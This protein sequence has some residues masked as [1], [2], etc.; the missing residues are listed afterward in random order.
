MLSSSPAGRIK[1]LLGH[2]NVSGAELSRALA[3]PSDVTV[4]DV[5]AGDYPLS[6]TDLVA[7]ADLLDVP[8]TVLTG[9]V[10]M[11][12]HLGVSL[13]LGAV[14][15]ADVPSEALQ[16]ADKVLGYRVLLDSWLGA[17]RSP[18]AGVGMSADSYFMRAGQ[19]SAERVRDALQLDEDPIPDLVAL[20]EALGYPVTFRRLPEGMHGL[21]IRDEREGPPTRLIIVS[22]QDPWTRQRFTLAHELCHALYD[23]AGQVIVDL[24]EVPDRLPELRAESFARHLLLPSAALTEDVRSAREEGTSLEL[25]TA[26]LM[27]R[28]GMSKQA[29]LR[30]LGDDGLAESGETSAVQAYPVHQLMA[31]SGLSEQ[32]QTLSA[33]QGEPSGS[34]WLVNRALEAYGNG[35]VGAHVVADLLGQDL[36]TTER[37]LIVQG[38]ATPLS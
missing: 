17:V 8:V 3:L 38:W 18:L 26:C 9:Q 13:R 7:I 24:V 1:L 16:Y 12:G 14:E 20:T 21:N 35:W 27:V 11:D 5:L 29:V 25:L 34:P 36:E 37:Q 31:R 33:G 4:D 15:A 6:A 23:D 10:P 19:R 32:W 2:S 28:W 30:A 22:T